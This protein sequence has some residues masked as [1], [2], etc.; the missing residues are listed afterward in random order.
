MYCNVNGSFGLCTIKEKV[1][2]LN[3]I[4]ISMNKAGELFGLSGFSVRVIAGVI[5]LLSMPFLIENPASVTAQ[6]VFA[7]GNFLMV[8]GGLAK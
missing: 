1:K 3:N 4:S 7:F 2:Y 8:I 5:I 6:I